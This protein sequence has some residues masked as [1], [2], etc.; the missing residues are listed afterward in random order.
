M[1]ST[2]RMYRRYRREPHAQP[3]CGLGVR[4]Q[5]SGSGPVLGSVMGSVSGFSLGVQSHQGF[6]SDP[7]SGF[8]LVDGVGVCVEKEEWSDGFRS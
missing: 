6:V 7:V 2:D 8:G 3:Y 1:F 4:S 5:S